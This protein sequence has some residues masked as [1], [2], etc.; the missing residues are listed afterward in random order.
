MDREILNMEEAAELFSVSV[1]TFIKL[2]KEEKIPA[3]KI[4]REWRF[5]RKSLIE[6]LSTGNSQEYSSS[7]GETKEFFNEVAQKWEE[8]SRGYYDESIRDRL[9]D[10]K[11]LKKNMTILDLGAG[12]GYLSRAIAKLVKRVVAVDISQEML[13]ELL[14]K[15]EQSG[16]KNIE[17]VESDGQDV[18]IGDA[19]IDVVC[20]S[21]YLHHIEEPEEAIEEMYRIAKPG[22]V[23]FLAD[24]LEHKNKELTDKMHDIWPGF[25]TS[26]LAGFFEKRG[27]KNIQ[28]NTLKDDEKSYE[29][30][31][32]VLTAQK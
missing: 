4:G 32:F 1:K 9:L 2:L 17:P 12:D 18:P 15:S 11:I 25:N 27:F 31:I 13:K 30:R 10:L 3:R 22:G 23:V 28:V 19:E 29:P 14:K 5:S 24:Y 16:I 8:I 7:E 26:K 6:W 21:M 20:A